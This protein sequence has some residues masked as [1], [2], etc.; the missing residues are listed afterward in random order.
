[1]T[2]LIGCEDLRKAVSS[3]KFFSQYMGKVLLSPLQ[4]RYIF[5]LRFQTVSFSKW[6]EAYD[7]S[8]K[9]KTL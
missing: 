2:E 3:S 5:D 7:Q 6:I 8:R 4:A 1:M 9:I